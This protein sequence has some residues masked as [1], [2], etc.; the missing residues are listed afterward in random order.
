MFFF[1]FCIPMFVYISTNQIPI[2]REREFYIIYLDFCYII[3]AWNSYIQ[4]KTDDGK[5]V[6][7]NEVHFTLE[8]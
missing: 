5:Y 8:I 7:L 3:P 4:I 2:Y 1:T 6:F